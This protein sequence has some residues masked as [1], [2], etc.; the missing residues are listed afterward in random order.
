MRA[1]LQ[2]DYGVAPDQVHWFFGGYNEPEHYSDRIR[3]D[4]PPGVQTST[5]PDDR[6][7]NDMLEAGEL[8]DL[9][10]PEQPRAF[11]EGSLP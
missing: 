6:C 3:V 11:L 1:F 9:M 10:G 5:I 2:H 7:M 8:D 4:L